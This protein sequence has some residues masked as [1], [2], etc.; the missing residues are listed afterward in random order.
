MSYADIIK[1]KQ[2]EWDCPELLS[3]GVRGKK[4]PFSSPLMNW[5]T[6]GGIPR[7]MITEFYGD[8]GSGKS[9]TAQDVC[10]NAVEIFKNEY[11][12]ELADLR[13]KLAAGDKSASD[14]IEELEEF[15]PKKVVYM[16]LEHTFDSE[17]A[18]T[19]GLDADDIDVWQPPN[20]VAEDVL[21]TVIEMIESGEVGLIVLDSVPSLVP[22]T[23]LEKKLGERTV[24]AL[25]GLLTTFMVKVIPLLTRYKCSLL[26]INQ[27][28]DNLDNPYEVNT[29]GGKAA[30]FYSAL[31]MRFRIGNPVDFLGNAL[32]KNTE[33]PAGYLI[34][35]RITKQK[36]APMDRKLAT[37]Y[38]M[39]QSGIRPDFDYVALAVKNYGI[40]KKAAAW[41]SICDP[42]T[43]E[44]L[45]D[46]TTEK[47]VKL[48]GLGKVYDY[49]AANT[50]YYEKLKKFITDDINNK[51]VVDLGA[52][53]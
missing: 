40:I 3:K 48:N 42:Y 47:P 7:D 33:N 53:D 13:E 9:T 38:L 19:L 27:I 26:N 50:E 36:S 20:V 23:V 37:Y 49:L 18:A 46:S 30:K 16:D 24:A 52:S 45:I 6:Y 34:T 15:G 8:F 21:Q 11:N 22:R 17:W 14:R 43:G 28:R 44:V 10:K 51:G 32:P 25:A 1:K 5:C 4:I 31:R 12:E 41:F 39:C 29:P 2:K 35:A